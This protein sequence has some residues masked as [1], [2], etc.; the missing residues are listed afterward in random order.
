MYPPPHVLSG[1]DARAP[2]PPPP[3]P[4]LANL[5]AAASGVHEGMYFTWCA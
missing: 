1:S 2:P 4:P 5:G 3:P